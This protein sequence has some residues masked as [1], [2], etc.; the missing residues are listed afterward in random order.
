MQKYNSS[1]RLVHDFYIHD[2][3][4]EI[5]TRLLGKVLVTNFNGQLTSGM[6]VE[7][8]AYFAPEDKASHAY[9]NRLTP[10]TKTMFAAGGIAYVYLCYGIH[11]LFNIVTGPE[12]SPHAVLIRGIQP[13]DGIDIMLQRRNMKNLT[14][15]LAAGPGV[16]SQA[17]GIN[18][19][20][21][22]SCLLTSHIWVEDRG[23]EIR[24]DQIIAAPRIG[25]AYAQEY[26]AKPWRFYL[27][28]NPWVSTFAGR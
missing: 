3:V 10:R 15:K 18:T 28:D 23:I 13:I 2:D 1:N 20:H 17:L 25:V 7:V 26:A 8:E 12:N 9:N 5:A 11:H 27:L 16:L 24:R 22:A 4:L 21:N 19:S 14:P 6:I